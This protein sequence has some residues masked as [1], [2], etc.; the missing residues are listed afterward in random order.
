M[1][2]SSFGEVLWDAFPDGKRLGGAPLNVLAR[3]AAL[4]ANASMI[5][6][7]G[8]D[9]DG[10]TLLT[11][12][13][14]R[15]IKTDLIQI[16][17]EQATGLVQVSLSANGSA[18]YDIVYPCAWDKIVADDATKQHLAASDVLIFGSLALRDTVSR[19]AL[20][21]LL[22][23]AKFKVFDVNLR[24]PHYRAEEL[25]P[26]LR[27]ADL[28]KVNDDELFEL[29]AAFGS[30]YFGLEQ[31][32]AFLS[33]IAECERI[34]VTLGQHGAVFFNAG[35]FHFHAGYRVNVVDTVGAGDNFLAG[36]V[37]QFLQGKTPAESLDFACALG[38]MVAAH[39]GANPE[40][41][42]EQIDAFR[43]GEAV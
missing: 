3:L 28:L 38:A 22:P 13:A 2:I 36:F 30:R 16:D 10:T 31:N 19:R 24:A 32:I 21:D 4:G 41:T 5:S 11:Q 40:I 7:V 8:D 6:R 14:E 37:F 33:K 26:F 1:N 20:N 23:L 25:L 34:C 12:I 43:A 17:K 29:A 9:A 42:R 27:Q 35:K 15:N 39:A 18:S